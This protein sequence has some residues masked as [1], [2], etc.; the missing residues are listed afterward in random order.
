ML[1]KCTNSLSILIEVFP[2]FFFESSIECFLPCF[3]SLLFPNVKEFYTD[4]QMNL[5]S[6]TTSFPSVARYEIGLYER[7]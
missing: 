2:S 4:G 1:P 6:W 5:Y 3:L 7:E